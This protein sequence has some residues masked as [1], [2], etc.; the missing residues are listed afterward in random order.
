MVFEAF[1]KAFDS[2]KGGNGAFRF[3]GE[4]EAF[5]LLADVSAARVTGY[6]RK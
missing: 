1:F 2:W 4:C 3:E 5:I 6:N